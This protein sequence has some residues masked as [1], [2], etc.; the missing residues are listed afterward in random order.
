VLSP[1]DER[2]P[3]WEKVQDK[4]WEANRMATYAAMVERM[5]AGIGRILAKLKEIHAD[6]NTLVMFLSDNGACDEVIQPGWYD[7]PSRTRDGRRVKVGNQDHSV[8]AGP[9]DVWQSYGPPWANV[10]NTPFRRYKHF[11]HEG[12]IATPFIVSWPREID[13]AARRNHQV[14]HVVDLMPTCVELAGVRRPAKF[15]GEATLPLEGRSLVP[16]FEGKNRPAETPLFWEHEGNC[17]VRLGKWKLVSRHGAPWELYD[18]ETDRTEL[19]NLAGQ[20]PDRVK[21]LAALYQAWAERC[22]VL[23]P[24]QLPAAQPVTPANPDSTRKAKEVFNTP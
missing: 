12:G 18:L 7:V 23:P 19:N 22:R 1:R 16:L 4:D 2:V 10:S 15:Q 20:Q 8:M 13:G 9:A 21:E 5:D 6:E 24:E 14:G 11:V 17:A 3:T